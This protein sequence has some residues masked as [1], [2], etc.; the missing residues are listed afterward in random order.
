MTY[1]LIRARFTSS[2]D[3][4]IPVGVL[5]NDGEHIIYKDVKND[6]K[7][8]PFMTK[9]LDKLKLS[10]NNKKYS[11]K[12]EPK[13]FLELLVNHFAALFISIDKFHPIFIGSLYNSAEEV[14]DKIT[15]RL[16]VFSNNYITLEDLYKIWPK[17]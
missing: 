13:L 17:L 8:T 9:G 14:I 11:Y 7:A 1:F 2:G 4:F 10:C 16:A 3:K 5:V 12:D 15:D 6:I